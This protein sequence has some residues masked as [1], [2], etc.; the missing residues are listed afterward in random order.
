MPERYCNKIHVVEIHVTSKQWYI[1]KIIV[2]RIFNCNLDLVMGDSAE[3]EGR[4]ITVAVSL[5]GHGDSNKWTQVI[6]TV[7]YR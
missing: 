3:R 7:Q 5:S 4:K 1:C 2:E 6:S